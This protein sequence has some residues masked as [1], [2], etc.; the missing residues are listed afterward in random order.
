MKRNTYNDCTLLVDSRNLANEV[1]SP[2]RK[3]KVSQTPLNKAHVS[4]ARYMAGLV[5]GSVCVCDLM[6][7][8]V[9]FYDPA[10][11]PYG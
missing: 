7:D 2:F 6:C 4:L 3:H 11:Q 1:C 8:F 9:H 10:H 5:T